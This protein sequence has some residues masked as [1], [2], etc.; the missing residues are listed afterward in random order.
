MPRSFRSR[1]SL[2]SF[3]PFVPTDF[4]KRWPPEPTRSASTSRMVLDLGRKTRP[5]PGRSNFWRIVR[6]H[7]PRSAFGS[8]TQTLTSGGATS[9]PWSAPV[10]DPMR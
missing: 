10:R 9:R 5:G 3:R 6:R 7:G 4:P 8:T 1:R 2:L